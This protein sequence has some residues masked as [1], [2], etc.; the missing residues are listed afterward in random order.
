MYL[1]QAESD[2]PNKMPSHVITRL[3]VIRDPKPELEDPMRQETNDEDCRNETK[4]K[5]SEKF[6][7]S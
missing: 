4:S 3:G 5:Q 6:I 2:N 7:L 1:L